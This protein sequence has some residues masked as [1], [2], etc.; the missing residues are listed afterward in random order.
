MISYD[1]HL[2]IPGVYI[3]TLVVLFFTYMPTDL[4]TN[5]SILGR[6]SPELTKD[7]KWLINDQLHIANK[8]NQ[9]KFFNAEFIKSS[10]NTQTK[11][12]D[13]LLHLQSLFVFLWSSQSSRACQIHLVQHK[14]MLQLSC[15]NQRKLLDESHPCHRGD[16]K[17]I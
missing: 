1:P 10:I 13:F 7:T 2:T 9:F 5:K 11:P 6:F 4:H 15:G 17:L 14:L 12:L 8:S 16:L 3:P